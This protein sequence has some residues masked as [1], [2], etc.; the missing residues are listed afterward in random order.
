MVTFLADLVMAFLVAVALCRLFELLDRVP[1]EAGEG[2]PHD[3]GG[4]RYRPGG[5]REGGPRALRGG[6][7][8]SVSARP[9]VRR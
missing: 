9:R 3:G 1:P 2:P 7:R 8:R 4:W 6:P 5:P